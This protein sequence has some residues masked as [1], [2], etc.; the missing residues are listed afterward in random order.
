MKDYDLNGV[1]AM[2]TI[3]LIIILGLGLTAAT[4]AN[5]GSTHPGK[6]KTNVLPNCLDEKDAPIVVEIHKEDPQNYSV[7][8][9]IHNCTEKAITFG[10]VESNSPF[11]EISRLT[12]EPGV[13]GSTFHGILP[14]RFLS[15]DGSKEPSFLTIEANQGLSFEIDLAKLKW[16]EANSSYIGEDSFYELLRLPYGE[17]RVRILI[18]PFRLSS[19]LDP[20]EYR[21]PEF[22]QFASNSLVIKL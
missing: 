17:Y 18:S 14:L 10:T 15:G 9:T 8:G 4:V 21:S 19:P 5:A 7:R 3:A 16:M 2:K 22:R 13:S 20:K 6:G 12:A 11:V 1:N